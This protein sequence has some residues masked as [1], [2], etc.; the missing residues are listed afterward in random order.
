MSSK[1]MARTIELLNETLIPLAKI[2]RAVECNQKTIYA[3][4][5]GKHVPNVELCERIYNLLSRDP[6]EVK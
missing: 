1:L 3:L 5:D 4:R 6:L 2:A